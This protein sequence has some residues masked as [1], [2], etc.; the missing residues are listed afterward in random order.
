MAPAASQS[1]FLTYPVVM[2]PPLLLLS[3]VM[4]AGLL[5]AVA[6]PIH[7]VTGSDSLTLPS[8]LQV[9]EGAASLAKRRHH[10]PGVT[11]VPDPRG[12]DAAVSGRNLKVH[13]GGAALPV[14]SLMHH[15][16]SLWSRPGPG[17]TAPT[18]TVRHWWGRASATA[19]T[20]PS[21][22]R[23]QPIRG[24][25]LPWSSQR[26]RIPF[27]PNGNL[28]PR[29]GI[30]RLVNSTRTT[31]RR[32]RKGGA[33]GGQP[34]ARLGATDPPSDSDTP[35][36]DLTIGAPESNFVSLTYHGGAIMT[37]SVPVYLIYYGDWTGSKGQDIIDN[38]VNSITNSTADG[39]VRCM[40]WQ[41]KGCDGHKA[42]VRAAL[43][44]RWQ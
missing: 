16:R 35:S 28:K 7:T 15:S 26:R 43:T 2:R 3:V 31:W 12:P 1:A 42:S 17:V 37:G 38:F 6:A 13:G 8:M 4:L 5:R 23:L 34:P 22:L 25:W 24:T 27:L 41:A 18:V 9:P 11:L 36:H 10:V 19:T 33:R 44:C 29:H 14:A 30:A 40:R 39:L 21:V 32:K 20:E